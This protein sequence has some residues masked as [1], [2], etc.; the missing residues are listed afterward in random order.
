MMAHA[1]ERPGFVIFHM[2]MG[3]ALRW[4][5]RE[6]IGYLIEALY[7]YSCEGNPG[8][9][10]DDRVAEYFEQM[11]DG[12]DRAAAHYAEC[13][14]Q[15]MIG[16]QYGQYRS[17]ELKAGREPLSKEEWLRRQVPA[18]VPAQEAVTAALPDS[19]TEAQDASAPNPTEVQDAEAPA[20][21]AVT[22]AL[23]DSITEAQDASAAIPAEPDEALPQGASRGVKAP[24][25][26]QSQPQSQP[27]SQSQTQSQAAAVG[28]GRA[29]G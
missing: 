29:R 22:A 28:R 9:F 6:Q 26:S 24:Q 13:R 23:P 7:N 2:E 27:Q 15:G 17:R 8:A 19:I 18:E 4:L 25:P 12:V 1:K 20:R 21:E 16:G 5:T 10:A 3:R 14:R 11:K